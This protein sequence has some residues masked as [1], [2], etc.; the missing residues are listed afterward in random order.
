MTESGVSVDP[1]LEPAEQPTEVLRALYDRHDGVVRH[2]AQD[3]EAPDGTVHGVLVRRGIHDPDPSPRFALEE[4]D[5]LPGLQ[6]ARDEEDQLRADGSGD[7]HNCERDATGTDA[8][9]RPVCRVCADA[10]ADNFG[11]WS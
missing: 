1:D 11:G 7:C 8:D 10:D 4:A 9:G 3:L 5:D 6:E 2:V